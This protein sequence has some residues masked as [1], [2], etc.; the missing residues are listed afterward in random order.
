MASIT[1]IGSGNYRALIR[2]AG[3]KT[4]SATFKRQSDAK[5]W[6]AAQEL[7]L[8]SIRHNGRA[9]PPVGSTFPDFIRKYIEEVGSV[10]PFGKNK[11]ACLRRLSEDFNGV[12]MSDM[13]EMSIGQYVDKRSRDRNENGDVISGVTISV[14]LSYISTILRWAKRV[15]HYD[16]DERA[17]KEVRAGL[18]ERGF[19]TRSNEREREATKAELE[20]I[21]A[22][23]KE[24]GGRQ[25]IPMRDI[26]V[27][28]LHSAMR[29]DEIC[30]IKI[31]D[32][33]IQARTVIIRDRKHP[34]KKEGNDQTV[35]VFEG[36]W[37]IA[38]KH[39]GGRKTGR[40]FNYNS[41]SVSSSFTRVCKKCGIKDLHFHDLRHTAIGILFERGLK[42]QEVAVVS[43]HS[44]WK[45][46]KRY[47]HIDA[48]DVHAAYENRESRQRNRIEM[49]EYLNELSS[50]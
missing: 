1:K 47:T 28:A 21:F 5:K 24:K 4:M 13:T 39:I 14:D 19:N 36:A 50:D 25:E 15:K 17:A 42:I 34:E 9:A 8:E 29:Q 44:D 2:K 3:F 7:K 32:I 22:E 41:K 40:I 48:E 31:D 43:G 45:M 35:P 16:V 10:K 6:A 27:F 46:L 49:I 12:L 18:K 20:K 11:A 37:N 23:Y 30:R 33:D 38:Q 26:I